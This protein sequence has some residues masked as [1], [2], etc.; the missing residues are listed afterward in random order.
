MP[1][2]WEGDLIVGTGR[3]AIGTLVERSTRYVMLMRLPDGDGPRAPCAR[4]WPEPIVNSVPS[5][6]APWPPLG[7]GARDERARPPLRPRF[8]GQIL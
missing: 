6:G 4:S 2:H 3:R 5:F 1:G 8:V 7:S